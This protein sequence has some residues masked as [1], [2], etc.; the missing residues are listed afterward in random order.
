MNY[1]LF[2][3]RVET[4]LETEM[5]ESSRQNQP[6]YYAELEK[7]LAARNRMDIMAAR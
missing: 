7:R 5:P 4:A 3:E 1:M 2:Y 6:A